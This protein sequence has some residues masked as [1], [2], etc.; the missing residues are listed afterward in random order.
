MV[1]DRCCQR[2]KTQLEIDGI[3]LGQTENEGKAKYP[4]G[5]ESQKQIEKPLLG[6][7][8]RI[9][10]FVENYGT[11]CRIFRNLSLGILSL[12]QK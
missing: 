3:L 7:Q 6:R 5:E 12:V 11:K 9:G 2:Q 4:R 1:G 10:R 8:R